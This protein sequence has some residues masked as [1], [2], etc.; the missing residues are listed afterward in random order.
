MEIRD[1]FQDKKLRKRVSPD[2]QSEP[3]RRSNYS[4]VHPKLPD[5]DELAAKF[6]ALKKQYQLQNKRKWQITAIV[7]S[8]V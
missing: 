2:Y 5:Y 7:I 8:Q 4:H 6:N 3:S 1:D